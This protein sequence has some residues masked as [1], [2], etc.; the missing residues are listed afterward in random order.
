MQIIAL[1]AQFHSIAMQMGDVISH[2][3][4]V[5]VGPGAVADTV[6]GIDGG[7][8]G[9]GLGA[10]IRAP[11]AVA[12][13]GLTSQFLAMAIGASQAAQIGTFADAYTGNEKAERRFGGLAGGLLGKGSVGAQNEQAG[14]KAGFFHAFSL[15]LWVIETDSSSKVPAPK[16][17][18]IVPY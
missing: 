1:L 7:L 3:R 16:T 15:W 11:V 9:S 4:T 10:Q 5:G 2:Y 12:G 13:A 14:N 8:V 18:L 6:A 17:A